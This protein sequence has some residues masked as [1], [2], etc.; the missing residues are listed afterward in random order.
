[1]VS[2]YINKDKYIDMF[3]KY[4]FQVVYLTEN[5]HMTPVRD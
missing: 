2:I 3:E 4:V 1:M 5:I